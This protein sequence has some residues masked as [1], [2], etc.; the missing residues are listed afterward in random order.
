MEENIILKYFDVY[1][2]VVDN[3]PNV[4]IKLKQVHTADKQYP[5]RTDGRPYSGITKEYYIHYL[6]NEIG[7]Q[8]Y[9]ERKKLCSK[10]SILQWY[11][12]HFLIDDTT[13]IINEMNRIKSKIKSSL[14]KFYDSPKC[15]STKL[16]YKKRTEQ[17]AKIIGQKNSEKWKDLEWRTAQIER[18]KM[19]GMYERNAKKNSNRMNDPEFKRKFIEAC[20]SPERIKKISDSAKKMWADARINDRDKFYRMLLSQKNKNYTYKH[21]NMNF[22]EYQVA[23]LLDE[24]S[25]DWKYEEVIHLNDKTYVP[26]FLVNNNI[27]IECFGDFWHANPKYFNATDTTHKTRMAHEVWKYDNEKLLN[28]KNNSYNILVLWET[29]I[30]ENIETCKQQIKEVTCNT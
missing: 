2:T 6:G 29:D 28:L 20:N 14:S 22:I 5:K 3:I 27:I 26:D 7:Y 30:L 18:R 15:E 1:Y 12:N 25:I 16:K 23:I 17:W 9:T 11:M 21:Y 24:L 4:K 19:S 13:I 10:T 8:V